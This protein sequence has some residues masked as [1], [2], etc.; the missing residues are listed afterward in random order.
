VVRLFVA[1][2]SPYEKDNDLVDQERVC[3]R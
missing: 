2:Y 3:F 1:P